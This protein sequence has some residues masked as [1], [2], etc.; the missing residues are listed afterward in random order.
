MCTCPV[1][2]GVGHV[3]KYMLMC[4][5]GSNRSYYTIYMI[6]YMPVYSLL[7][8]P[9]P[10]CLPASTIRRAPRI[11][12]WSFI[13]YFISMCTCPVVQGVGH[14]AKCMLMCMH[15]SNRSYYTIY[16]ISYMPVYSLL[17]LPSPICLPT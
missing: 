4:M 11:Y 12:P 8:L 1:V 14:V 2:Q 16:M 6:S 17:C 13:I 9:S 7:C 10:I 3:A 5:H 15:G